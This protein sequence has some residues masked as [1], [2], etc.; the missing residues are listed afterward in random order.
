M[1]VQHEQKSNSPVAER[2]KPRSLQNT[3][4]AARQPCIVPT[5]R[6]FIVTEEKMAS[7]GFVILN[8]VK[9][10]AH[11]TDKILR[12]AQDDKQG[13]GT[14][15]RERGA[16]NGEWGA[17]SGKRWLHLTKTKVE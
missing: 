5:I 8:E 4:I 6:H 9:N 3:Q 12:C 17:G 13:A 14:G 2:D 15:N 1:P 10:L 16:G 11:P 7:P